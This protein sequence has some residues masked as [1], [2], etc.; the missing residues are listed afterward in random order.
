MDH[1]AP[2]EIAPVPVNPEADRATLDAL[3]QSGLD[4]GLLG[5]VRAFLEADPAGT[6]VWQDDILPW[7]PVYRLDSYLQ[8]FRDAVGKRPGMYLGQTEASRRAFVGRER[9]LLGSVLKA[10][11]RREE[12]GDYG[13]GAGRD[14]VEQHRAWLNTHD[15][16]YH[17]TYSASDIIVLE[18]LERLARKRPD[19]HIGARD[20]PEVERVRRFLDQLGYEPV[21]AGEADRM[22]DALL[23][24]ENGSDW[25]GLSAREWAGDFFVLLL[26][27]RVPR[28]LWADA[29]RHALGEVG[30]DD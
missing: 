7:L 6:V 19:H 30:T 23:D 12:A 17:D 26:D 18:G 25:M 29:R 16:D 27:R 2:Y 5:R 28:D 4:A 21:D 24:D 1:D 15:P 3:E 13:T 11:D 20:F 22:R 14:M 8:R 10:L 9:S